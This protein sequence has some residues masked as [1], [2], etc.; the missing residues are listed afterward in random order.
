MIRRARTEDIIQIRELLDYYAAKGQLLPRSPADIAAALGDFIIFEQNGRVAGC[1]ALHRWGAG[2]AEI[3]SF[4][5]EKRMQGKGIGRKLLE[6]ALRKAGKSGL[7]RVFTLT[8]RPSFFE[9]SGFRRI[10][11]DSLPNKIWADC[12]VCPRLSKCNEVPLMARP[13]TNKNP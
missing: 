3:R 8:A 1:I 2:L 6:R 11:K 13:G 10:G 4:A 12:L 9:K 7:K 5:V